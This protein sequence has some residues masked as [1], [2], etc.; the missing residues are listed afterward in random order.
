M[1]NITSKHN[2]EICRSWEPQAS[3]LHLHHSPCIYNSENMTEKGAGKDCKSQSRGKSAV[4]LS[5]RK[6]CYSLSSRQEHGHVQTG[7]V[8][9]LRVLRLVSKVNRRGLTRSHWVELQS[10]PTQEHT[11]S[12]KATTPNSTTPIAQGYSNHH[13]VRRELIPQILPHDSEWC[14][15]HKVLTGRLDYPEKWSR[16]LQSGSLVQEKSSSGFHRLT[17]FCF[18]LITGTTLF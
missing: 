2:A 3:W 18:G 6:A 1:E 14:D 16:T 17:L 4:Q 15:H 5:P 13:R 9:E 11:S 12:H 10:T 8:Q 7:T